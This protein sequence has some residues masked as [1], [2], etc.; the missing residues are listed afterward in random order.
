MNMRE[1]RRSRVIETPCGRRTILVLALG[2]AAVCVAGATAAEQTTPAG[3]AYKQAG[4]W[5]KVGTGDGQFGTTVAGIATDK[6]GNVYVADSEFNRVQVLSAKGG[7]LRKWGSAGSGDGQF[8]RAGDV[9]VAPDG[10]VWVADEGN[11]RLQQFASSGDFKSS[12]STSKEI[13]RGVAVDADGNVLAA[14]DGGKLGGFRRFDKTPTGWEATGGLLGA[15]PYRAD[16]VEASPDGTVYLTTSNTQSSD[17][18]VRRY[19]ADGKPMGSIK[20]PPS[21][22]TRGIGIDLDCNVLV[23]VSSTE[24][25]KYSPSGK[26]LATA[27][28]P[29]IANDIAVGPKGDLY[30]SIQSS[31]I[32][33]LV[34]DR[35]KPAAAAVGGIAIAKK[36]SGYVARVKYTLSGVACPTQLNATASLT[37]K[38]IAGKTAVKVAAGKTT[39]IEIPLK[40]S[41]GSGKA[42]FKIVLKTN[43]RLTTEVRDVTLN[44]P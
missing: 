19:S 18:R 9:D 2:I 21:Y 3:P 38:G 6:A 25:A 22:G 13:P 32:A 8:A 33:H 16:E 4:V 11:G 17:D 20:L 28:I 15:G 24:V 30:V 43:G 36:G 31:G 29:Y 42:Q 34:E 37:G 39:I 27:P 14:I 12:L 44:V 7:F 23:G 41:R 40:A 35:S 10:S 5:G 1:S 26:R